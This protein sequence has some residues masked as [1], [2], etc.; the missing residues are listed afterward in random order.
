MEPTVLIVDDEPAVRELLRRWLEGWGY[1]V[2]TAANATHALQT[3]L[4]QP[5]DI[6]LVDLKMPGA[7]GFWLI[8]RVR[9]K[10]P[11]T[12]FIMATGASEIATVEK[13]KRAGVVDYVLKPFQGELLHQALER[14]RRSIDT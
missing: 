11:R 3:M 8:D 14:A 7:D 13:S 9:E 10:W 4:S 2:T 12:G 5:A 6:V 1:A